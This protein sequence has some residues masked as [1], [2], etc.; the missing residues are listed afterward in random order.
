MI[1]KAKGRAAR[2]IP[3]RDRQASAR[4][5]LGVEAAASPE[6]I[7]RAYLGLMQIWH[8]DRFPNDLVLRQEAESAAKRI[9]EAYEVLSL[10]SRPRF[11]MTSASRRDRRPTQD[12][13][14]YT[15]HAYA[16]PSWN[17][18]R[19]TRQLALMVLMLLIWSLAAVFPFYTLEYWV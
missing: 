1:E 19:S 10:P 11:G 2:A 8:P 4:E 16:P 5:I 3:W 13:R 14:D 7:R 12:A 9:N 6:T 15:G 17:D 18:Q